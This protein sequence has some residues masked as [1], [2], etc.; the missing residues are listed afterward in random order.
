MIRRPDL[1]IGSDRLD[2]YDFL[3][4]RKEQYGM[5][6]RNWLK[7][8]VGLTAAH[9]LIVRVPTLFSRYF[10][11]QVGMVAEKLGAQDE[12]EAAKRVQRI[13]QL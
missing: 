9:F 4:R 1:V 6:S 12:T 2:F 7:V 13:K 11:D 3:G 5:S 8:C 10:G